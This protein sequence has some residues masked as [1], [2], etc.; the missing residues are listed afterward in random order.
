MVET[1]KA[2]DLAAALAILLATGSVGAT[3]ARS[4]RQAVDTSVRPGGDFHLFANGIWLKTASIPEGSTSVD[5]TSMLR[6]ATARRVRDLIENADETNCA[7]AERVPESLTRKIGAYYASWM[8]TDRI[9][10]AGLAPLSSEL[11]A[12]AAI[13][14]RKALSAWLGRNLRSDDG[15]NS[16]TEG[17]LGVWVHQG[18]HDPLHYV[19]HLVQGGLG[20]PDRE[21]YLGSDSARRERYREHIAAVLKLAGAP[22]PKGGAAR[23]L[24]MEIAIARTHGSRADLDDV[25]KTDNPWSRRDFDAKAPGMNWSAYFGAA[26]L[27]QHAFVVWQ[28]S[29]I[30]GAGALMSGQPLATWRDYLTFRLLEHY[31]EVLPAPFRQEH[32][33]FAG[34]PSGTEAVQDRA[35]AA[36][37]ATNAALGNGVGRLYV[38]RY[39][40]PAAKARAVRMVE[41]IRAAYRRHLAREAWMSGETR[42]RALAKL[43]SLKVGLGYPDRWTDYTGL[44]IV[45]GDAQGNLRRAE[46]FAYRRDVAKLRKPVDPAEWGLLP[47]TVSAV[48]NFSPNAIQFAAGLLQPP[49]FDPAGDTA[50][51]F[52]SAGAA[53]AHE[54]GHSF[55]TLGN[56][57]DDAG[58]L[59]KWWTAEDLARYEAATAP[60][61]AQYDGYCP[62]PGLCVNG[63]QVLVESAADLIG[64]RVAYDAYHL[65][66]G[67]RADAVKD[68]STGDQRFFLAFAR[69]WRRL[70]SDQALRNQIAHDTHAPGH[71]RSST[72]RNL[73]A[74]Y[75]A[76]NVRPGDKLY[77]EPVKRVRIGE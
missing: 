20:L 59:T 48:I 11:A 54:I 24:D 57:Y 37:A 69:R 66:L 46:A 49:Y 50:A 29:A 71:Y 60:L 42:Q 8:D 39:F 63:K 21:D 7:R 10:A 53:I 68:G 58:R 73:D 15:T 32:R 13:T 56:I 17:L 36:I 9:D 34:D 45:R 65:A 18:F 38:Q 64:L 33:A 1:R 28:P 41:T 12:I 27:D 25:F 14:D 4:D 3:P 40:P 44:V 55:D 74:W 23:I 5:T 70:Q 62:R 61:A 26:G 6:E 22:D 51:N 2:V 31:A 76:F 52:G 16:R 35:Q 47:Q 75:R 19:P 67:D 72:V 77:L 30:I 43:Q